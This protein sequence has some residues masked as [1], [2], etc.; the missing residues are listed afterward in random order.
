M[1]KYFTEYSNLIAGTTTKS[2]GNYSQSLSIAT[3]DKKLAIQ[4]RDQL[5]NSLHSNNLIIPFQTHTNIPQNISS[6][7]SHYQSDAL[8]TNQ[9]DILI[10]VLT[11]DCIPIFLYDPILKVIG[12]I[13][14]G[15]QGLCNNI[16]ENTIKLMVN[17]FHVNIKHLQIQ[18]GPHICHQCYQVSKK[19]FSEF[20]ITIRQEH[21]YL[22]MQSILIDILSKIGISQNQIRITKYCTYCSNDTNNQSLFYSYRR[23]KTPFRILSFIGLI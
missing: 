23:D 17:D 7:R 4:S 8:I 14:S 21:D 5:V 6:Y 2:M 10:G 11:A 15:R 3:I 1:I 13:H 12:I 9:K 18:I 20:G 22:N 19:V 16:A